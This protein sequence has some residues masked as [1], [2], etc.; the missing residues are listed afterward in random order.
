[1]PRG[2]KPRALSDRLWAK[3]VKGP[4]CWLW[5]GYTNESG[6]G[7]IAKDGTGAGML[8]VHRVSWELHFGLIPEDKEVCHDCPGGD[9]P[10]CV[11]PDHLFL[12]THQDNMDDMVSKGRSVGHPGAGN[13]NAVLTDNAVVAIRAALAAGE[14]QIDIAA[15]F[16]VAQA[17][18]SKI[19]RNQTWREPM[20]KEEAR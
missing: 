16:G 10:A 2:R 7:R 8:F 19:H 12:G 11:N 4:C 1:M 15:R 14:R 13:P 17:S 5:Q 3:V 9:N 6:H 20:P 18:V